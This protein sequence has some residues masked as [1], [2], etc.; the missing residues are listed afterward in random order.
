MTFLGEGN[1]PGAQ[2]YLAGLPRSVEPAALVAFL[3]TYWDLGWIL[4]EEQKEILLRL[5]PAAFD[6]DRGNWALSLAQVLWWRGDAAQARK[7]A[8]EA[9]KAFEDQLRAAP[10]DPG[11]HAL[12]G[13]ALA[14]LGRGEEAIREGQRAVELRPVAK[15]ADFGTYHA[16]QLMRIYVLVGEPEKAIDNLERLLQVPW[17]VSRAWL[18]ID[19]NFDPLR[20][21]P[22]FQKLVAG[23]K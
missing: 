16:H 7:Y 5:T 11:R 10:D 12:L 22:R 14:Y 4:T 8:E 17:Y 21:N 1:L 15:D 23:A 9:R 2:A 3:A 6:G 18:T 20:N 13:V 19:P